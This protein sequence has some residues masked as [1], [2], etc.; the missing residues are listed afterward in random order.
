MTTKQQFEHYK[1]KHKETRDEILEQIEKSE[2]PHGW[3]CPNVDNFS[4]RS[5]GIRYYSEFVRSLIKDCGADL[6]DGALGIII[7]ES[8]R[9][10]ERYERELMEVDNQINRWVGQEI[11]RKLCGILPHSGYQGIDFYRCPHCNKGLGLEFQIGL[12]KELNYTFKQ[13]REIET[14]PKVRV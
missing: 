12:E 9:K 6:A 2:P 1:N 7:Y 14:Y 4:G 10:N 3:H 11:A 8:L 5:E 13:S